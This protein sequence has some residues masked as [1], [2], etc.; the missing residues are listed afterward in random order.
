MRN[1]VT[2][3]AAWLALTIGAHAQGVTITVDA[4]ASRHPISPA[5]YGVAFASTDQLLALNSPLNRSGGNGA[6]RYNWQANASSHAGDWF[7][8]S[9]AEKSAV[10]GESGDTFIAASKAAGAQP[11]LTVPMIGWVAKLGPNRDKLAWRCCINQ[12]A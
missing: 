8:E 7:F 4:Q 12:M 11:M 1:T 9:I 2:W 6:T 5:I 3:G 10:P